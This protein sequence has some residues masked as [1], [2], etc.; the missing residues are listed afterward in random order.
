M[1]PRGELPK[2]KIGDMVKVH[3]PGE[4]PWAECV[5]IH[6]DGSWEGRITNR[7]V[8]ERSE[9]ERREAARVAGFGDRPLPALHSYRKDQIVRFGRLADVYWEIWVPVEAAPGTA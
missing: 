1:A 5:A 7:L 3:L 4:S 8:A 9:Q 2:P 6:N